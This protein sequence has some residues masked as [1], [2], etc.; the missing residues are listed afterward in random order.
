M[1]ITSIKCPGCRAGLSP[2]KGASTFTCEY[3]G[4]QVRISEPR[5]AGPRPG[6]QKPRT[7]FHSTTTTTTTNASGGN[8]GKIIV[9]VFVS[10]G[11]VF[12]G[13][14]YTVYSALSG[15]ASS[16]NLPGFGAQATIP[17]LGDNSFALWNQDIPLQLQVA[18]EP[19]FLGRIRVFPADEFYFVAVNAEG[20]TLY[21]V[22]SFGTYMDGYRFTF[23]AVAGDR[24]AISDAAAKLHLLDANTGKEL[25]TLDL[26]D[27]VK[28]ICGVADGSAFWA[29]QVDER[30]YTIDPQSGEFTEGARPDNCLDS[31]NPWQLIPS[32]KQRKKLRKLAKKIENFEPKRYIDVGDQTIVAGEREP[33]TAV[34]QVVALDAED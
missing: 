17:G 25:K 14:S 8:A 19:A 34:P 32:D 18:G 11:L 10:L 4:T 5:P 3:C 7:R 12:A 29:E 21:R 1:A 22:G 13:V 23:A 15:T 9:F 27:R 33:G 30:S 24:I 2:P 20:K 31:E 6:C 28:V 26:S 16:T